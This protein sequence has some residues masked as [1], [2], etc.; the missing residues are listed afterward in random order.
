MMYKFFL[1]TKIIF[2]ENAVSFLPEEIKKFGNKTFIVCGK[3]S[4]KQAGTLDRIKKLL[5]DEGIETIIYDSISPEPDTEIVNAG[6]RIV[7]RE[8]CCSVIG[9]GGG[10]AI[11]VAKAVAGLASEEHSAED[12]LEI[13]G[14]KK[15]ENPG[16]PFISV[17]T[18][19]GT[20]AEVTMNSVLVNPKTGNKRSIRSKYLFAKVAI[21]DP[22]L[23]LT[24]PPDIT[25]TSGIDALCHLVE[26]FISKKSNPVC[27]TLVHRGVKY[28]IENLPR[29]IKNPEN[30]HARE[31][32]ALASLYGG[33]MI[34]NSG[35]TLAHGIGSVIGPKYKIPHGLACAISLPEVLNYN[36]PVLPQEKLVVTR[37][38]FGKNPK[39][40]LKK[41]FREINLPTKL[42]N[43]TYITDSTELT[44]LAEQ[45]LNTSSAKGNPKEVTVE[46]ITKILKSII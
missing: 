41:F 33:I 42:T 26:G 1:P 4:I 24:V 10:S 31:K 44:K 23:T 3:K 16:R 29:V 43:I 36:L 19:S 11:D 20:G 35:L 25:A 45:I 21:I 8:K 38:V 17:P 12:Y 46:D 14:I 2:G 7:G 27:D 30:L 32:L 28:V 15:I 13:D 5:N 18:V 37:R 40:F 34:A 6:L 22:E 39:L 9:I